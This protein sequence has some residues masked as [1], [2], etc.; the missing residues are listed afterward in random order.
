MVRI[1]SFNVENLFSRPAA[2][3][4]PEQFEP[5]DPSAEQL[6]DAY[7]DV[8]ELMA[9]PLYSAADTAKM[10]DHL[11]TLD[12]YIRKPTGVVRKN[13]TTKP[14]WAWL[15]KNRGTFDRQ[16]EDETKS[17]E[18]MATGRDEWTGWVELA[19]EATNEV[20]TRMTAQVLKDVNAD[21]QAIVEAE[22]RPALVRFNEQILGGLYAAAF[23]HVMLVDG[24]DDRGIDVGLLTKKDFEIESIR[25]NVD[26][27][28][29]NGS[30]FRLFSR[31]CAD[32]RIRTKNGAFVRVLVNHFKSQSGGGGSKRNR[33]SDKVREIVNGLVMAGEHV[34]VLGDFNEGPPAEGQA[35]TNLADLFTAGGPLVNVWDL[36][37]FDR[38]TP[39]PRPGS[40]DDCNLKNRLDYILISQSLVPLLTGAGVFRKG[41]WGDRKTKP[42]NWVVY[43]EMTTGSEQA[44]DHAAIYVDLNI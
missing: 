43:D 39:T 2:F 7:R 10:I 12:I 33:Q 41:L 9:L 21:I 15:R 16:P 5:G 34:V 30:G 20:G 8:N 13:T 23:D 38:G 19:K 17:V 36:P 4:R 6:L 14:K 37:T 1:A 35:P 42:K 28:D 3:K 24:N 27:L 26:L 11:V 31:D 40:Y 22:D 25:S 18:I 29:T 32:Y 44:S